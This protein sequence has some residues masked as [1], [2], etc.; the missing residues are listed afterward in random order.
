M[1]WIKILH[2]PHHKKTD[3]LPKV[4]HYQVTMFYCNFIEIS[5]H[6]QF[7]K[8]L[9]L[10]IFLYLRYTYTDNAY[11]Y[12]NAFHFKLKFFHQWSRLVCCNRYLICRHLQIHRIMDRL[13]FLCSLKMMV[14]LEWCLDTRIDDSNTSLQTKSFF[15]KQYLEN[16][17]IQI[18]FIHYD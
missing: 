1:N 17:Q 12:S 8:Y 18:L 6:V 16:T 9:L 11:K 4:H 2:M 13:R 7:Q 5:I 14:L 10:H 15:H 3:K